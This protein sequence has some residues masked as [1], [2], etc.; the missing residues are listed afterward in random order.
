MTRRPSR[1]TRRTR[2]CWKSLATWSLQFPLCSNH[3]VLSHA[4]VLRLTSASITLQ[5]TLVGKTLRA[6]LEVV[7]PCE[8]EAGPFT[9][10]TVSSAPT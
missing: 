5:A 4:Q 7:F 8:L 1:R 9:T 3:G 2:P 6:G 10:R